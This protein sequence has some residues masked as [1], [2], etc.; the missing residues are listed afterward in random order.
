MR[1]LQ[2]PREPPGPDLCP[3]GVEWGSVFITD[4]FGGFSV[5]YGRHTPGAPT[6]P[7]APTTSFP[8]SRCTL[9]LRHAA[10]TPGSSSD[11]WQ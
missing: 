4:A 11:Q 1:P 9:D 2:E 8:G 10:G 6:L 5:L 3:W 7:A